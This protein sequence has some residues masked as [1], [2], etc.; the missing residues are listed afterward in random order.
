MLHGD[1]LRVRMHLECQYREWTGRER[2]HE[3]RVA[4]RSSTSALQAFRR[5]DGLARVRSR[6]GL[7]HSCGLED[8]TIARLNVAIALAPMQRKRCW[9]NV[10]QWTPP[11]GENPPPTWQPYRARNLCRQWRYW[12]RKEIGFLRTLRWHS[13]LSGARVSPGLPWGLQ[14]RIQVQIVYRLTRFWVPSAAEHLMTIRSSS[15]R[16]VGPPPEDCRFLVQTEGC[17]GTPMLKS[18]GRTSFTFHW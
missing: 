16:Y 6:K 11:P 3:Q 15:W 13:D 9:L 4:C 2:S 10:T 7:P 5:F 14:R 18:R 8:R 12:A 1:H 17:H